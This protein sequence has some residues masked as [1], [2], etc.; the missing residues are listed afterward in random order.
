MKKVN[1]MEGHHFSFVKKNNKVYS[2][3]TQHT[4]AMKEFAP[5]VFHNIRNKCN[6]PDHEFIVRA[7]NMLTVF[8]RNPS[9]Q[10]L[11]CVNSFWKSFPRA[12]VEAFFVLLVTTST[13]SRPL[14][15]KN[16]QCSERC[17]PV[18]IM[19]VFQL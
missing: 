17:F 15:L 10:I 11:L 5:N 12:K 4:F 7:N 3:L 16:W 13:L 14:R 19:C 2:P 6:V 1:Q 18:C 9:N 8:F